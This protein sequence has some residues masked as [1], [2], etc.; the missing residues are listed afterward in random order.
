MHLKN[1]F[2]FL[3]FLGICDSNKLMPIENRC[4]DKANFIYEISARYI[5]YLNLINFVENDNIISY[6]MSEILTCATINRQFATQV[7]SFN[8]FVNYKPKANTNQHSD[9]EG[10]FTFGSVPLLKRLIIPA[11]A[12]RNPR[13]HLLH[14][15]GKA[16][17]ALVP[18][19][20]RFAWENYKIDNILTIN[21]KYDTQ[22]GKS[23]FKKLL[24]IVI[25]NEKPVLAEN[26]F[27]YFISLFFKNYLHSFYQIACFSSLLR[28]VCVRA[29]AFVCVQTHF[30]SYFQFYNY[31]SQNIYS[32]C[33][34]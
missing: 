20:I 26:I 16:N 28:S 12:R 19:V 14:I 8:N 15:F 23:I 5:K 13:A 6:S 33:T 11:T 30:R 27:L 9:S 2:I 31:F 34:K 22:N 17:D 24:S 10:Y 18:N 29:Y 7:I 1:I 21:A 25:S 3:Y 4:S 32:I